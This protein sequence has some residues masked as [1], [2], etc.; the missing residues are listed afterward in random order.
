VAF[1]LR[2]NFTRFTR[3]RR[4][5]LCGIGG[6]RSAESKVALRYIHVDPRPVVAS[7]LIFAFLLSTFRVRVRITATYLRISFHIRPGC[8]SFYRDQRF[9]PVT[10]AAA[11]M[12][13]LSGRNVYVNS[14]IFSEE[15]PFHDEYRL[16]LM[17]EITTAKNMTRF[18]TLLS[19][20]IL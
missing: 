4:K 13:G 19:I 11:H 2:K 12:R 17:A 1:S 14:S 15:N 16:S 3:R 8:L 5:A 20:N 7:Y 6:C 18:C 9:K 10:T